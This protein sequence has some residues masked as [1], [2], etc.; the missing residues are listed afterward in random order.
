MT[1]RRGI[2]YAETF[3]MCSDVSGILGRPVE[4]GDDRQ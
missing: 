3:S 4:P 2:Q 1:V